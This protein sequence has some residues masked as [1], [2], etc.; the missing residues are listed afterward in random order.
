MKQTNNGPDMDHN[1]SGPE[2]SPRQGG[3]PWMITVPQDGHGKRLVRFLLE[4]VPNLGAGAVYKALDRKDIR[5]N[6]QKLH[7][8]ADLAA[9]DHIRIYLRADSPEQKAMLAAESGHDEPSDQNTIPVVLSGTIPEQYRLI[10]RTGDVLIV[11]KQPGLSVQPGQERPGSEDTLISLL[12]RDLDNPAIQLCHRIDRQTGGL[13]LAAANS[14]AARAIRQLMT[15]GRL[16][17]R[18]RCLVRGIPGQGKP[19][20]TTDGLDMLEIEAWLEK[21]AARSD[22]YIHDV[23]QP[24]DV[25]VTTRYRILRIFADAG[26]DGESISE[27]EVELVTGRTHQIRAHFAHL[28][29]PLLGDG[30]YGRNAYNKFFCTASGGPLKRQQLW[31][32]AL[33]FAQDCPP[34]CAALAGRMITTEPVYDLILP[35]YPVCTTGHPDHSILS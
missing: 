12:R 4:S 23:K 31:A 25:P 7:R 6:G 29:H 22:V 27:L 34:P 1:L 13:L 21:D 5:L 28:G 30:K 16:H 9:G 24:D 10:L 15:D 35:G 20:Q 3:G 18:Y 26:P 33:L 2:G 32:T 19:V 8:D 14:S 11:I 17:K